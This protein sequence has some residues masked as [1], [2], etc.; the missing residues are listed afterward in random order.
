MDLAKSISWESPFKFDTYTTRPPP[1]ITN[2]NPFM[3]TATF[4]VLTH[5]RGKGSIWQF[6]L[7]ILESMDE[8][9]KKC[10]SLFKYE[11]L[12][13]VPRD[14]PLPSPLYS[15]RIPSWL[16]VRF[17]HRRGKGQYCWTLLSF[18]SVIHSFIV[19]SGDLATA[20]QPLALGTFRGKIRGR[21]VVGRLLGCFRLALLAAGP[22]RGGGGVTARHPDT[23]IISGSDRQSESFACKYVNL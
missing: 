8:R 2:E 11:S 1:P 22:V 10:R 21:G 12:V 17:T 18:I 4:P 19:M 9:V 23:G 6:Y 20:C 3:V 13:R 16:P 15:M 14:P 5:S 7:F